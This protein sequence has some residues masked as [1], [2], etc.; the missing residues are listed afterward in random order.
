MLYI[1]HNLG[2]V[3]RICDDVCVLYAGRVVETG[4]TESVL[5]PAAPSVYQ[6][7]AR[8]AA[9][10][11]RAQAP[12]R[13][14]SGAVSRSERA[15]IGLHFSSAMPFRSRSVQDRAA[16]AGERRALLAGGGTGGRGLAGA[17][18]T[19]RRRDRARCGDRWDAAAGQGGWTV[20]GVSP[21]RDVQ[22]LARAGGGRRDAA[23]RTG[24]SAGAG[25][26]ERLRQVHA[27][28]HA[29]RPDRAERR[30]DR[31]RRRLAAGEPA[32]RADHL[33]EPG[34]LAQSEEDGR[35]DRRQAAGAARPCKR[36]RPAQARGRTARD[37]AAFARVS[38]RAIRTS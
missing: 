10:R 34:L 28:A 1:T 37:G 11:R 14:D 17:C 21:G 3:A 8:V 18:R 25:R 30:H 7:A 24:R 33:P 36:R 5:R 32:Q 31:H 6:G 16:G 29:D 13:A 26:R 15:T 35:G 2:V 20:E 12:S 27:R 38:V 22:F 4:T 9:A 23:G 19:D